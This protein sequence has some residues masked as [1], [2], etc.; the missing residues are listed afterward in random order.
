MDELYES[1]ASGIGRPILEVAIVMAGINVRLKLLGRPLP[2]Q[3]GE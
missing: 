1:A 2:L 3:E